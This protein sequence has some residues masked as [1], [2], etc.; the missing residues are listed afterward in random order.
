MVRER[1][2]GEELC[3]EGLIITFHHPAGDCCSELSGERPPHSALSWRRLKA[4]VLLFIIIF[5]FPYR[6]LTEI[7]GETQGGGGGGELVREGTYWRCQKGKEK[8]NNSSS[9]SE[10]RLLQCVVTKKE[11]GIYRHD[12]LPHSSDCCQ[13]TTATRQLC[14]IT[15]LR[16]F[17]DKKRAT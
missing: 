6:R 15:L 7:W 10:S 17:A 14:V 4:V 16:C 13:T 11:V 3:S 12:N 9:N 8:N 2:R 1:W 5:F